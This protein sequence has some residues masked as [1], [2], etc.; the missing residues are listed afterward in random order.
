MVLGLVAP[1]SGRALVFD[2]PSGAL[3]CAALRIGSVLEATDFHRGRTG[4]DH[5]RMLGRAVDVPDSPADEVLRLV[6]PGDAARRRVKGYSLGMRQ[7]LGL[8]VA[9]L[10][11]P[12]L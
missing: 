2:H 7:Q 12:D 1:T 5:L 9:L 8:A 6:V 3:P 11:G 4:R 10:G